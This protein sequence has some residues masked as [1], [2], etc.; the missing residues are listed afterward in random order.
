MSRSNT[1]LVLREFTLDLNYSPWPNHL[2]PCAYACLHYMAHYA[3]SK[4]KP[5]SWEYHG[6][7]K[8]LSAHLGGLDNLNKALQELR[9][10]GLL[11][12]RPA[13]AGHWVYR[14][15]LAPELATPPDHSLIALACRGN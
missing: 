14:F 8:A 10:K 1:E 5:D 7:I 9:D 11:T 3:R 15:L 13:R 6:S 12:S 2:G 4:G